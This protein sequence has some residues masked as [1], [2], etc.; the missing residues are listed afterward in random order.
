MSA[1]AAPSVEP[2]SAPI[3]VRT[4]RNPVIDILR[5]IAM[6]GVIFVN[7]HQ[8]FRLTVPESSVGPTEALIEW[9]TWIGFEQKAAATFALLFGIGFAIML[10]SATA[11]GRN[12]VPFYLRRLGI[13]ALFGI[14]VEAFTGYAILLELA[15]WGVPLLL[16]R[17]WSSRRLL[18]LA[19]AST[20]AL[21]VYSLSLAARERMTGAQVA[22]ESQSAASA[23]KPAT[24][25]AE[26]AGR[27]EQ[28]ERSYTSVRAIIPGSTFV[29]YLIGL[30]ALRRGVFDEPRRHVRL[31]T[32]A[33]AFGFLSWASYWLLLPFIPDAWTSW[34]RYAWPIRYGMGIVSDQW[35]AFTYVGALLLLLTYRQEWISRLRAFAAV[36]RT[37][38]TVYVLQAIALYLLHSAFVLGLPLRPYLRVAI[39]CAL[40]VLLA[41]ASRYWL[42]RFRMGPLEWI[43]R[44]GTYLQLPPMK[45]G[46]QEPH[47]VVPADPSLGGVVT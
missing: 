5:G 16:V 41:L 39:S 17:N 27:L 15:L 9:V 32:G 22:A 40:F 4:A 33:M 44:A 38:L 30:L 47:P 12:I 21:P 28:M 23:G 42:S 34:S 35:L 7:F 19:V 13:L 8:T 25:T 29:L 10:R 43:W 46:A 45:L 2:L 6:F 18:V 11:A 36:G 26:V 14:A 31:I 3:A 37:S 1:L 20:L 24:Y